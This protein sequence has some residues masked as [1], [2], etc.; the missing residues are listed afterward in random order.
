MNKIPAGM[1]WFTLVVKTYHATKGD[2]LIQAK[3]CALA[4]RKSDDTFFAEQ[5]K[6][7][8]RGK[9]KVVEYKVM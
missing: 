8:A 2:S 1:K 6:K 9:G 5:A 3:V 7:L 4:T